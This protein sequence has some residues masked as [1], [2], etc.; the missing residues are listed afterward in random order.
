MSDELGGSIG[1][2]LARSDVMIGLV[3]VWE[4]T[5]T[6]DIE[7]DTCMAGGIVFHFA[8]PTRPILI[9][10]ATP[11]AAQVLKVVCQVYQSA[12]SASD[13]DSGPGPGPAARPRSESGG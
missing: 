13:S 1:I 6:T 7:G 8:S 11:H 10:L 2:S 5:A 3:V 4:A 9:D 12:H